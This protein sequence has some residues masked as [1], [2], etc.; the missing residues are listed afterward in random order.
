MS[1]N[2]CYSTCGDFYF[3][4]HAIMDE[5]MC[6]FEQGEEVEIYQAEKL[7]HSHEEFIDTGWI[8]ENMVDSVSENTNEYAD[9]YISKLIQI[10]PEKQ[11]QLARLIAWW[12]QEEI[13]DV[14][15]YTAINA[16]KVKMVVE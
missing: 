7:S 4:K 5:L 11:K 12:I 9:N 1:D 8:I 10:S 16:R 2:Y 15:F 3:D 6:D 13:G 14:D